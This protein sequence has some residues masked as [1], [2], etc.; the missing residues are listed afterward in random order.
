MK[1]GEGFE[2]RRVTFGADSTRFLTGDPDTL[3]AIPTNSVKSIRITHHGGGALEG[4]IIGSASG[5]VF[6]IA[7]K[8]SPS[9]DASYG[10]VLLLLAGGLGGATFGAIAGHDYTFVF[11]EDSLGAKERSFRTVEPDS[12]H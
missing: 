11:P 9:L 4:L 1:S 8:I 3:M 5:G 10:G 2:A 12:I 6:F 7:S